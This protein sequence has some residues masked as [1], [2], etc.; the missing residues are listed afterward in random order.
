VDHDLPVRRLANRL[1]VLCTCSSWLRFTVFS[2]F[3]VF[4][5]LTLFFL[6]FLITTA[7]FC[8]QVF[9]SCVGIIVILD[10]CGGT[11]RI[12][13]TTHL[14]ILAFYGEGGFLFDQSFFK[15][16][17]FCAIG[18]AIVVDDVCFR[19]FWGKLGRGRVL[20]VP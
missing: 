8:F 2:H 12:L 10:S 1:S 5:A 15:L 20:G 11:G 3:H 19:L 4:I 7:G 18:C 14:H 17:F 9:T 13:S 16:G 6:N